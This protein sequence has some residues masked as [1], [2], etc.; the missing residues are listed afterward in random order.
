MQFHLNATSIK[1]RIAIFASGH[2]SN[3]VQIMGYFKSH[4]EIQ[5]TGVFTNNPDAGVIMLA[6]KFEVPCFVFNKAQLKEGEV[7]KWL[8]D[9]QV[10]HLVLAGFLWLMPPDY[11]K[12]F[13][14]HILNIHPS[15]LP[16]FGGAGMF[17]ARVHEAV[18]KAGEELMGITIH[19][20]NEVFDEGKILF[21]SRIRVN[22]HHTP[23][24]MAHQVHQLEHASYPW[25]I[26]A[27][28]QHEKSKGK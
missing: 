9:G 20:V 7:L 21:Q 13:P 6:K 28:I 19:Q 26:E 15:L 14:E 10:T 8:A 25:V 27:R 5:V 23:L 11:I 2:G 12:A 16:K 18:K 4:R 17:G 22:P 24:E 3:A 1:A